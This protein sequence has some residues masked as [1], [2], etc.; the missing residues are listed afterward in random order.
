MIEFAVSAPVD[1]APS[2]WTASERRTLWGILCFLAGL[3][4]L[5]PVAALGA[6]LL[7]AVAAQIT[8]SR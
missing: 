4:A 1:A 5:G 3:A 8:D 7:G 2:R 6:A